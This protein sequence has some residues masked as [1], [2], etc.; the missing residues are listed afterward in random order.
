MPTAT[1]RPHAIDH[2]SHSQYTSMLWCSK[3]YE[4]GRIAGAPQIPAWWFIGGRCVHEVTEKYDRLLEAT[5]V[6]RL[7]FDSES[8]TLTRLDEL[9]EEEVNKTGV[10]VERWLAAGRWPKKSG[11]DWWRENAPLMVKRFI[12]WRN[13]TKWPVAYFNGVP[14]IECDLNVRMDFGELHGAPDR[15]YRLPSGQLV[16][17]DVK[18]GTNPPKEPLQLGTYANDLEMLGYERPAYGTYVMVKSEKQ[19]IHTE[20]IPLDKYQTPYL[21][22]I[23]GSAQATIELGAFVPNVGDACR[24]CVVQKACYAA[25]GE[26]SQRY[27]RLNPNYV[28]SLSGN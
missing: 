27:D 6:V 24:T 7:D 28:G 11:Y 9:V 25:G 16:V 13:E 2:L 15:V 3:A 20:L 17:A 5:S 19:P 4:L 21:E 26:D 14:G 12:D 8:E 18:S 22:Q 1:L 23:Y 10:P